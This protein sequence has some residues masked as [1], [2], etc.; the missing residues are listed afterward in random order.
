[1]RQL[2]LY[3]DEDILNNTANNLFSSFFIKPIDFSKIDRNF[4]KTYV[5]NTSHKS[6]RK[7]NGEFYTKNKKILEELSNNIF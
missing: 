6:D 1:M 2:K 5:V 4:I 7:I 3:S